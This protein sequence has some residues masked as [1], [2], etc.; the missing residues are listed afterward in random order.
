MAKIEGTQT[1]PA[2][3]L[4]GYRNA[5][6]EARPPNVIQKRYPFR[7]PHFQK[8]GKKVTE[9]QQTQRARFTSVID[10]FHSLDSDERSRW[11][12]SQPVWNSFL[13]YYNF[14][15][16]SGL[17]GMAHLLPGGGNLIRSINHYAFTLPSGAPANVTVS[18]SSLDP[19]KAVVF[20]YGGGF[21]DYGEGAG[22][23]SYPMLVSMNSSQA[24][25]K[26]SLHCAGAA[27][28][29]LSIIEYI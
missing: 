27:N 15:M 28:A 8:F 22:G 9:K 3:W 7:L 14:F 16:L 29:S 11:Y 10:L 19:S 26:A 24:I 18:I 12:D 25:V 1:I 21:Y 17:L 4:D 5:L 20:F 6:G 2:A 23:P 13:W